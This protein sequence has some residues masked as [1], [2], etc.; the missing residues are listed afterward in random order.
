MENLL[1]ST[2][3]NLGCKGEDDAAMSVFGILSSVILGVQMIMNIVIS[4]NNN[5]NNNNNDNNNNNNNNMNDNSMIMTMVTNTNMNSKRRRRGSPTKTKG[6]LNKIE[7]SI[8]TMNEIM[9]KC[10]FYLI[11]NIKERE[12]IGHQY[13]VHHKF[14]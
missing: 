2:F 12:K 10:T 7:K 1:E 3:R 11:C 13:H 14:E 9:K 8:P 6:I 5:N 4:S